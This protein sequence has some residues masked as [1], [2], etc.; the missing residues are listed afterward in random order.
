MRTFAP[1]TVK[2]ELGRGGPRTHHLENILGNIR[3]VL[4]AAI[5][6]VAMATETSPR[7]SAVKSFPSSQAACKV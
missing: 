5:L 4:V 2:I 6:A 7:C 1:E 3:E